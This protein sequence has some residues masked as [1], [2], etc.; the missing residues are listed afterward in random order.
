M[1]KLEIEIFIDDKDEFTCFQY[2]KQI[3]LFEDK[4]SIRKTDI[5]NIYQSFINGEHILV[6]E[7]DKH[8]DCFEFEIH[9]RDYYPHTD[10]YE[11]S[12]YNLI[13]NESVTIIDSSDLEDILNIDM[14]D[15]TIINVFDTLEGLEIKDKKFLLLKYER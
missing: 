5:P 4:L 10:Q 14:N 13:T 1:K 15:L 3:S 7:V 11:I 12:A 8:L 2:L 9:H 6:I